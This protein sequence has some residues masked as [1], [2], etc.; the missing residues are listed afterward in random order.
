MQW[1]QEHYKPE[2]QQKHEGKGQD[3]QQQGKDN[4]GQGHQAEKRESR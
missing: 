2:P 4:R 1:D 3:K